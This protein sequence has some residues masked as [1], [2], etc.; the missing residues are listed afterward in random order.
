V[1]NSTGH[2]LTTDNCAH[3]ETA[4]RERGKQA[5]F[6][7][8]DKQQQQSTATTD[9]LMTSETKLHASSRQEIDL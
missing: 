8:S 3:A 7:D 5:A 6:S 9:P 1:C 4:D 2:K